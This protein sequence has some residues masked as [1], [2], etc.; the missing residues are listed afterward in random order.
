MF[1]EL[2]LLHGTGGKRMAPHRTYYDSSTGTFKTTGR[3]RRRRS[4]SGLAG[5]GLGQGLTSVKSIKGTMK[6]LTGV[7][8]TGG[9]AAAG[10]ILAESVYEKLGVEGA[11][12]KLEGWKRQA[13]ILAVGLGIALLVAKYAKKPRIAAA[14]AIGPV[15][16]VGMRVF[17][18]VMKK[19][20]TSGLGL[21][22]IQQSWPAMPQTPALGSV[23]QY[24]GDVPY[25][26]EFP[27]KKPRNY[28]TQGV[29]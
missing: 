28:A 1:N 6:G 25:G 13:A 15:V 7:M 19:N 26:F 5:F 9:I 17:A 29:Y 16:A 23:E 18:D 10:A 20:N 4:T 2:M 12:L 11:K 3:R 24:G 27:G 21:T 22:T 14:L 8:L